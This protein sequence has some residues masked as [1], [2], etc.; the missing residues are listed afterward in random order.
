MSTTFVSVNKEDVDAGELCGLYT[1]A[2]LWA[3]VQTTKDLGAHCW[4]AHIPS[5][6]THT[7]THTCRTHTHTQRGVVSDFSCSWSRAERA[8]YWNINKM[9]ARTT[10]EREKKNRTEEQFQVLWRR[11]S[12]QSIKYLHMWYMTYRS[13]IK[14]KGPLKKSALSLENRAWNGHVESWENCLP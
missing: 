7:H 8:W 11:V 1:L 12:V 2:L 10:K 5:T 6:H 4:H 13:A 3:A 9:A 14:K